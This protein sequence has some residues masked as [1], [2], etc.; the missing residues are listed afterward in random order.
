MTNM[1]YFG[2]WKLYFFVSNKALGKDIIFISTKFHKEICIYLGVDVRIHA[3]R[4][5]EKN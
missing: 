1:P 2:R 3:Q 4:I 5:K